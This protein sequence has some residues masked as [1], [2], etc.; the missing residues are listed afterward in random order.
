LAIVFVEKRPHDRRALRK[1][2]ED[3][4]QVRH[5]QR[6]QDRKEL[7][8]FLQMKSVYLLASFAALALFHSAANASEECMATINGLDGVTL[9]GFF[10]GGDGNEITTTVKPGER[11]IAAPPY[12]TSEQAW[13]VYL[14][15]GITGRIDRDRLRVLPDEPLM[16]L[17]YSARKRQWRKAKSK[18]VTE[19]DEAAWQAKQHGVNYYD[20]L[21][22]ASEG[23]LKAMARFD[24]LA[25]FMDG[26]A[27]ESYHPEWWALFHV[28]GDENFARYLKSRSAKT[29]ERYKDTFS[30]VGIEGFDPISNPNPY[31]RQ[32]FPKTYKIVFGGEQ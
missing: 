2:K 21:I 9:V 12:D 15:S 27:G 10:T 7:R 31:I 18:Q 32:N 25:K 1:D 8:A 14:K 16:K 19:N 3:F 22:R 6:K 26:A 4:A 20:T 17:N 11:F 29:R 13:R 5:E 24:S 30:T 23:N 28:M